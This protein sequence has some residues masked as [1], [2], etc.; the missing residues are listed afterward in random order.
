MVVIT[1]IQKLS[2]LISSEVLASYESEVSRTL[3]ED[4]LG[5]L[6]LWTANTGAHQ[7]D[8]SS[9]EY[10]LRDASHIRIQIIRLLST[11]QEILCED[12]EEILTGQTIPVQG[13]GEEDSDNYDR[14]NEMTEIQ[15]IFHILVETI[16]SLYQITML[17]R[18]PAQHDRIV[19]THYEDASCYEPYDKQH[20]AN[21]FPEADPILIEKLGIDIS[22]RR[23][24]LKYRER[25]H[26][27]FSYKFERG[28]G[29]SEGVSSEISETLATSL[30]EQQSLNLEGVL[31]KDDISET[32]YAPTII[33]EAEASPVPPLPS[34]VTDGR[35]FECPYCYCS[36]VIKNRKS[37][38]RHIFHDLEHYVC[39]FPTCSSSTRSYIFRR[40]WAHHL[41]NDHWA[42]NSD[43]GEF[44]C[45]LCRETMQRVNAV[46]HLSRHLEDLFLFAIS[47]SGG[48]ESGHLR[49]MELCSLIDE[50]DD[51]SNDDFQNISSVLRRKQLSDDLVS[52]QKVRLISIL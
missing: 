22:R 42:G 41:I 25:H 28:L 10:K 15:H 11:I 21:K 9:L 31:L 6:R 1:C 49:S 45:P 18:L 5:R 24:L 48:E 50:E 13:E 33:E 51:I 3:W 37:W 38:A 23:A 32:S 17:I 19:G 35:Q 27:I 43:N 34:V 36:I 14:V 46:K 12:L 40:D 30:E 29:L 52:A 26:A 2:L 7:K 4:E 16:S 20:V 39:V 8:Q 47:H 44:E